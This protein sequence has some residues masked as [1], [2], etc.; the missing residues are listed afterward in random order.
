MIYPG[1]KSHPQHALAKRQMQGYGGI[2]SIEVKGGLKKARSMLERCQLFAWP[3]HLA[4]SK[5]SSSIPPS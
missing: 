3:N 1:L 5:V 2:I 4:A